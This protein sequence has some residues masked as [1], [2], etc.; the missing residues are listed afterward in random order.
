MG[1]RYLYDQ[2]G[3]STKNWDNICLEA[4]QDWKRVF[5]ESIN[6][7][8]KGNSMVIETPRDERTDF[9]VSA[10]NLIN[11]Y[12]HHVPSNKAFA[13][14]M[15]ALSHR[16]AECYNKGYIRGYEI[17]LGGKTQYIGDAQELIALV[18]KLTLGDHITE[19]RNW[20]EQYKKQVV[21]D[22]AH[23]AD[24]MSFEA[25]HDNRK[26][27]YQVRDEILALTHGKTDEKI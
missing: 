18:Q 4:K 27:G 23:I 19:V 11:V 17:A 2:L 15:D 20:L 10:S 6:A 21:L 3:E 5:R 26:F 9:W 12:L 22:C 13:A 1:A 25:G 14:F 16:D 8:K 24:N 7:S